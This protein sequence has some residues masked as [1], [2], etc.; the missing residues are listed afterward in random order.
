MRHAL[1]R[2]AAP[3][4]GS[5]SQA[6]EAGAAAQ[7]G[8]GGT[9]ENEITLAWQQAP[10]EH[11]RT[12]VRSDTRRPAG[13]PAAAR[14]LLAIGLVLAV[15]GL[16]LV[17]IW[18]F[19][20]GHGGAGSG[21]GHMG[22]PVA[23][24]PSEERAGELVPRPPEPALNTEPTRNVVVK[25]LPGD[26]ELRAPLSVIGFGTSVSSTAP[27]PERLDAPPP[28]APAGTDPGAAGNELAPTG[29]SA[30]PPV[31]AGRTGAGG[32]RRSGAGQPAERSQRGAASRQWT[33]TFF[34][35]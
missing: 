35:N 20:Q 31:R 1:G 30:A 24:T 10:P 12:P 27:V 34:S 8:G 21:A 13:A 25:V 3:A 4:G 33:A 28:A 15:G 18:S 7:D 26:P 5:S 29:E 19:G 14:H 32:S 16:A 23:G 9:S 22:R 17:A 2:T 6:G 11:R